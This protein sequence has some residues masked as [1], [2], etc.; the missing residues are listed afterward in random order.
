MEDS[1]K[2]AQL[3]NF[4]IQKSYEDEY[5]TERLILRKYPDPCVDSILFTVCLKESNEEIGE[6]ILIYDGEIWYRIEKDFRRKGYATEAV[7]KL[8]EVSKRD[9]FYLSIKGTN[10]V[11][12]K[13]AKKLGFVKKE[14]LWWYQKTKNSL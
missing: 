3:S 6:V 13:V 11:S 5:V 1:N 8:M 12:K 10:W 2:I 4:E 7:R 14:K 9:E